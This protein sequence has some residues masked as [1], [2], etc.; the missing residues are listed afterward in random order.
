MVPS[1]AA[2]DALRAAHTR[3]AR[4]ARHIAIAPQREGDQAQF[5]VHPE[6]HDSGSLEPT[7]RWL[8]DRLAE[9]VT[10]AEI[11]DH[12]AVSPR[13]L[14]RWFRAQT[15]TTPLR[16]LLRQRVHRA[17]ELLETTGLSIEDVAVRCGFGTSISL[18]QRFAKLVHTT[19]QAYR[20]AFRPRPPSRPAPTKKGPR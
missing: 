2:L 3:G 13:T 18:R 11:A 7:M 9:P 20:R 19:P 16:W 17:Q 4:V 6:P 1:T 15:G 12:A 10:L 5:I 8:R 14:S